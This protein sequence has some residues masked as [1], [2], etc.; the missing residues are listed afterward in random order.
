MLDQIRLFT[1]LA[2]ARR[3][4]IAGAGGGFDIYAGLPLFAALRRRGCEVYLANLSFTN[5]QAVQ[6]LRATPELVEIFADS[7]GPD[8][9]FPERSLARYLAEH[10]I[11][12]RVFA[13]QKTGVVGVRRAY[14]HLLDLL[15]L[16]TLILVDGGT[17]ILMRGDEK[18]LGTPTEDITSLA[19]VHPLGFA[20][21]ALCCLGFGI[22]AFHGVAHA[23]FLEN[24]A[25]LS[26]QG[27]YW[28]AFSVTPE[29]PEAAFYTGAVDHA[30][31]ETMRQSIVNGSIANAIA[32]AYGDKHRY[33]ARTAG[34]TLWI[35]P[36]MAMYFAFDL[37][38][39]AQA[40]L[41]LKDLEGCQG[42][43]DVQLRI[44]AARHKIPRRPGPTTIP[45]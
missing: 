43:W 32:G 26:V 12:T 21:K 1:E 22:D 33:P 29:M 10:E 45:V 39:V 27:G 41:Y 38:A 30:A 11:D 8:G 24:V 40:N 35:N 23:Q 3:V 2:A 13:I 36:L 9:Y 7:S 15:D 4:L 28:G 19:A 42:V 17:D 44:E 6:G 5:L 14:E 37:D 16:D 20:R 18:G 34:S 31:G 25:S